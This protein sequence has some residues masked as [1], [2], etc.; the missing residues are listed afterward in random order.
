MHNI[1]AISDMSTRLLKN[2]ADIL[3]PFFVELRTKSLLTGS[4]PS[5]E[6]RK[7][8]SICGFIKFSLTYFTPLI[9]KADLDPDSGR[10]TFL[11]SDI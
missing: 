7:F 11:S 1:S 3:A 2:C 4:V 10:C 9:K 8:T 5:A 6:S